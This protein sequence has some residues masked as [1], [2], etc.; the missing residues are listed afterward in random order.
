V[1]L[2]AKLLNK[3]TTATGSLIEDTELVEVLND[4]KTKAKEVEQIL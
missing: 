2:D 4:T 1:L 3:L